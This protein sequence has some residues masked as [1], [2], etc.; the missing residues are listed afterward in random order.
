MKS[1]RFCGILLGVTSVK[2]GKASTFA[3]RHRP[4]T[5][6][7]GGILPHTP[8]KAPPTDSSSVASAKEDP[9]PAASVDFAFT[10]TRRSSEILPLFHHRND[11]VAGTRRRAAMHQARSFFLYSDWPRQGLPLSTGEG[12]RLFLYRARGPSANRRER[13]ETRNMMRAVATFLLASF[14]LPTGAEDM[15]TLNWVGRKDA[16]R[17][18]KNGLYCKL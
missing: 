3:T 18:D 15:P 1:R 12:T 2:V 10:Q 14:L 13:N 9:P 11:M 8:Q 16:V 4:G 5:D 17:A 7:P 6:G